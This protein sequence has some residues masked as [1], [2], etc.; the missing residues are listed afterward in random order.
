MRETALFWMNSTRSHLNATLNIAHILKGLQIEV[1][2]ATS[3]VDYLRALV[4][5]EGF[6]FYGLRTM[7]FG[8]N[9]E[10]DYVKGIYFHTPLLACPIDNNR[11][12]LSSNAAKVVYHKLGKACFPGEGIDSLEGKIR[13]LLTEHEYRGNLVNLKN[14]MDNKYTEEKVIEV[15]QALPMVL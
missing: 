9:F 8:V 2:Y 4:T 13:S 10:Y 7:P 1:V 3:D 11:F 14:T 6:K 5:E 15:I 12:D